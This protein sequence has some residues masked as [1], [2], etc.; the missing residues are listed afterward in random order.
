MMNLYLYIGN[1][2]LEKPCVFSLVSSNFH[3][4]R[5]YDCSSIPSETK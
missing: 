4:C 2:I 3:F 1:G 5:Y